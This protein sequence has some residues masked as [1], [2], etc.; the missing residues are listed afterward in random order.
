MNKNMTIQKNKL[1][2]LFY[3]F[4]FIIILSLIRQFIFGIDWMMWMMDFMGVFFVTFGLFKLYDLKGFVNSFQLYDVIAK[5]WLG[6]GYVYPFIEIILGIMYLIGFMFF[7]QNLAA[8]ILAIFGI[9]SAHITIKNKEVVKCVCLGS[10]FDLP[11]TKVT[12][13][14]NLLMALMAIVMIFMYLTM[15]NMAM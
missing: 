2:P 15:G 13:I 4:T 12:L 14:E 11:M 3:V 5:R 1:L 6:F 7:L 9:Y 10:A 8:L